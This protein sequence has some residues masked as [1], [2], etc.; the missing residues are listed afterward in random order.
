M[1]S[2]SEMLAMQTA[3]SAESDPVDVSD[4]DLPSI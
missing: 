1:L 4:L 3:T 2:L